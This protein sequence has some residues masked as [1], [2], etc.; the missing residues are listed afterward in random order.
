MFILFCFLNTLIIK[1]SDSSK[2]KKYVT[3][4]GKETFST[5]K[6]ILYCKICNIKVANDKN[7]YIQQ[8]IG[9]NKHKN[10][11]LAKIEKNKKVQPILL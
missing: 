2:V 9:R 3:K 5:N 10:S 7:F 6:L 8:H 1:Q 4:F 11:A